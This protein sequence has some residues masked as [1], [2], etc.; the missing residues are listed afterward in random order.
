[1]SSDSHASSHGAGGSDRWLD[2]SEA[3]E[4]VGAHFTT[5]R[6]WA[7]AGDV[8]CIR[9][10]GGRRR[11][12]Q[13]DLDRFVQR[14][15]Q[16]VRAIVPLETRA[17][18]MAREELKMRYQTQGASL[19]QFGEQ[20]RSWFKYSGQRLLGLLIQFGSRSDAGEAFLD[21]GRRL[22]GEYGALCCEAGM[23]VTET[24]KTF[25]FFGH[26]MLNTVQQAGGVNGPTDEEGRRLYQRMS[27]FLDAILLSALENFCQGQAPRNIESSSKG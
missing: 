4:Y 27:D 18:D 8:P 3:A 14:M 22:A 17:L 25:L 20:Q 12:A 6:R 15:R 5:L 19:H 13:A 7:D 9:T 16:P 11:F 10:P 1:M 23:S 26:S 21:E 2:L 24:V